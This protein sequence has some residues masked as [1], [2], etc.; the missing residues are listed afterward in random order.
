M[1]IWHYIYIFSLHCFKK[2]NQHFKKSR[3]FIYKSR[4]LSSWTTQDCIWISQTICYKREEAASIR[5]GMSFSS[6][7]W[8]LSTQRLSLSI[9]CSQNLITLLSLEN[10]FCIP[11]PLNN[12]KAKA[13]PVKYHILRKGEKYM[14]LWKSCNFHN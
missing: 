4:F 3:D 6:Q 13:I 12:W 7:F 8:L 11:V 5:E 14:F 10:R 9:I 2:L 1:F